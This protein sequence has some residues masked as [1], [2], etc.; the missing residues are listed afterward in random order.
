MA[1]ING[2][3]GYVTKT[4]GTVTSFIRQ[5]ALTANEK[6]FIDS[7]DAGKGA[8]TLEDHLKTLTYTATGQ[9]AWERF[10]GY[11]E[12]YDSENQADID[13]I[14]GNWTGTTAGLTSSE[15]SSLQA[16]LNSVQDLVRKLAAKIK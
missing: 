2:V 13:A 3:T 7:A 5:A 9:N 4:V 11:V 6:T 12:S 10:K 1:T 16:R 14:A 15:I 8:A